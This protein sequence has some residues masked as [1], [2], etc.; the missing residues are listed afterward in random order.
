MTDPEKTPVSDLVEKT[1]ELEKHMQYLANRAESRTISEVDYALYQ[2][3]RISVELMTTTAANLAKVV[4]VVTEQQKVI[5][6]LIQTQMTMANI[7][8]QIS[9]VD[10]QSSVSESHAGDDL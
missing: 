8:Q 6:N 2:S 7:I 4:E 10:L 1:R 3:Q 5:D 9:G